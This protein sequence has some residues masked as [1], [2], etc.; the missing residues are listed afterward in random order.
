MY[1]IRSYYATFQYPDTASSRVGIT[2]LT[3][4]LEGDKI[5]I[6]GVGGTGSYILD[7]LAKIPLN[8]IL[9]CDG[10]I[11]EPH[12]AF[13]SPGAIAFEELEKKQKK[14]AYY[15]TMYSQMHKNRNN[16]V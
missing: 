11:L 16:F 2:A 1:A 14:V 13:R 8:K 4:K 9:I 5:A 7:Q 12:N 10:D 15:Q 3:Q 6:I